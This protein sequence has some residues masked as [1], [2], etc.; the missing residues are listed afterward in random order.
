LPGFFSGI[1][2]RR[3]AA[4]ALLA[5][6]AVA[7]L[8]GGCRRIS[9]NF[10]AEG[11][12]PADVFTEMHYQQTFRSQ[13]SPRL[14]PAD[15]AVPVTGRDMPYTAAEYPALARPTGLRTPPNV[16]RGNELFRVNCSQCHGDLG[17]GDG[18]VGS[19]LKANSYAQPPD[20]TAPVTAGRT[21]GEI[22]GLISEGIFVMPKFKLLLND[23]DRW[24]LVDHIRRLQGR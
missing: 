19:V 6:V 16:A 8:A 9:G 2:S 10:P 12:Y 24:L 17:K 15:G 4:L 23:H 14:A 3:T 13:E 7:L 20:L 1:A 22:F 21:D 5:L 11:S 18:K